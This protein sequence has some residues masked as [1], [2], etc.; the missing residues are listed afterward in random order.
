MIDK[1]NA[2]Q[3]IVL[4]LLGLSCWKIDQFTAM[5]SSK[6]LKQKERL[7]FYIETI[8]FRNLSIMRKH[9]LSSYQYSS[10]SMLREIFYTNIWVK[11]SSRSY[12]MIA[13]KSLANENDVE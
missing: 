12:I 11:T 1:Q 13:W 10:Q 5:S 4:V 8:N 6:Y 9:F 7:E 2:K 3:L